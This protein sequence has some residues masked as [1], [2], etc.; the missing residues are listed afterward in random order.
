MRNFIHKILVFVTLVATILAGGILQAAADERPR[1]GLV[2]GG[3][4]ARGIAHIGVLKELERLQI[5]VDAIAGTSMG[6]IVGG[7]YASG[8]TAAEL[9]QIVRSLDWSQ[10]LADTPL[11]KNLSFRRK[12]DD[13]RYPI[14]LEL[15]VRGRKIILPRGLVH[16]Q[17]LDPLLRELTADVAQ[18]QDFSDLPIPFR[19]VATDIET[20]E[21]HVLASGD[22]ARSIRA[23]MS[24]PGL[25]A[26]TALDGKLLVDGGV[27]ANLP[28]DVMRDMGVDIIIAVDVEFPLYAPGE[29]ETAPAITEQMLTILMRNETLRQ[30]ETLH[31]GD[32]LIRPALGTF[33]SSN[34]GDA[35]F[36]IEKGVA[37]VATVESRLTQL[38]IGDIEYANHVAARVLTIEE[39]GELDFVRIEHEGQLATELM[40]ARIGVYR[41]DAID[42]DLLA[43]GASRLYG[44]NMFEEVG[45]RVVEDDEQT[46]VV[47][48]AVSKSWGPNFLNIGVS[49]QDDFDGTTAFNLAARMTHT[50]LNSRGAEWRTDLQLGT[51]L[52]LESE[53]YQPFGSGL[54]Y[55]VAPRFLLH[56][57]N[58]NVF[59]DGQDI[60]QLRVAEGNFGVD[61]GAELGTYGEFR[62]GA[63]RGNGKY[64]LKIGDPVIPD[65]EY[66]LG[67]VFAQLQIDTFDLSRFPRRGIGAR[68]R[69]DGSRSA[70]GASENYDRLQFDFLTAW[71]RGKST[72]NAG[73]SYSTTFETN[74]QLQDFTPMGGFLRLSGLDYGQISGPHA[75]LAK[76]I[77][78]R[79]LGDYAGGLLEAPVYLGA[80]AEVGNVWQD[81]SDIDAASLLVN[82][83]VFAA[84]DT[85]FGAIYLAVG[86]AEGG[87]RAFY[88]SIGSPPL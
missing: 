12:Q 41:G 42:P 26:P 45:Y 80:S 58:L 4:G 31:A 23:S 38:G 72:F 44:L 64:R 8:L 21:R 73:L 18:I 11:R 57:D 22:L 36:P 55:F 88:L 74:D 69:W 9:E 33:A 81:G 52:L 39:P 16:G 19:A 71:S 28:V 59:I 65:F 84:F 40:A 32:V 24:V 66:E 48:T 70:L 17:N 34:F 76:L 30:I 14:G 47:Y 25:I 67:A 79:R 5:P 77:Y 50:G 1:I 63:Y 46:G 29:L 83:S 61:L 86:F 60:A 62:L 54:K 56:Q 51:D 20:G 43:A 27:V 35:E 3:G 10:A 85:F 87:D 13:V 15:G 7:L 68:L 78:Y 49:L 53:F 37:A 82:G 2:L 75:A 6:A